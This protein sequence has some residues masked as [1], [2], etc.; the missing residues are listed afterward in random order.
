MVKKLV[1]MLHSTEK[2]LNFS[3][4]ILKKPRNFEKPSNHF[5]KASIPLKM[6][7]I[8]ENHSY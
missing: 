7:A 3:L 5:K 4:N 6:P 2:S 8:Y 1:K